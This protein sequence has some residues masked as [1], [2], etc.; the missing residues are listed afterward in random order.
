MCLTTPL[1]YS[2]FSLSIPKGSIFLSISIT[3]IVNMIP[4]FR[5]LIYV[6][7]LIVIDVFDLLFYKVVR[8]LYTE[9]S[10]LT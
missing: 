9:W 8:A 6:I 2:L 1:I 7:S 4:D 5:Y 10:E 3:L